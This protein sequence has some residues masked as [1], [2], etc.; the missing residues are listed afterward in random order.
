MN[1]F[2]IIENGNYKLTEN[3]N[4]DF[5]VGDVVHVEMIYKEM[6][7][8]LVDSGYPVMVIHVKKNEGKYSFKCFSK[9]D[10]LPLKRLGDDFYIKK[11]YY[12]SFKMQDGNIFLSNNYNKNRLKLGDLSEFR[13]VVLDKLK[14]DNF[15][16]TSEGTLIN[17]K[18]ISCVEFFEKEC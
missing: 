2:E 9:F 4:F 14:N 10:E 8:F 16:Q 15:I 13:E 3:L 12:C 7:G 5:N 18:L 17:T 6:N 11:E 1:A